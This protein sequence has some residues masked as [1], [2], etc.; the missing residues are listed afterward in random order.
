MATAEDI[1]IAALAMQASPSAVSRAIWH[2]FTDIR[3]QHNTDKVIGRSMPNVMQLQESGA[4]PA[5]YIRIRFHLGRMIMHVR[6]TTVRWHCSPSFACSPGRLLKAQ[7]L[8]PEARRERFAQLI[9]RPHSR[10]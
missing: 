3:L 2:S 5:L 4:S 7:D 9:D 6:C 8:T 10:S 1:V